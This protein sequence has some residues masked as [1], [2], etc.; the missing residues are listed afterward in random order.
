M[1]H[2][3]P[4][5][6]SI[7]EKM[8]EPLRQ[9]FRTSQP[10]LLGTS[11]ATGF[12]ETAVRSGVRE[13]VLVVDG[14]YFGD[15]F[16]KVA[17]AC[18]KEVVRVSIHPGRALEPDQLEQ[19][20]DGPDVDAVALV[21]SETS[22]GALAPLEELA[23]VIRARSSALIL[24]DAVTSLGASPVETDEWGLDFVFTGSQK[25]LAVPPGLALA[26][27]S[28]RMIA[29]A[30][31]VDA[32]GWYLDVLLHDAAARKNQPT[33]TPAMPQFFAL[34]AQLERIDAEGGIEARWRRHREMQLA[35]ERW[36]VDHPQVNFLAPEG[37]RSWAVSALEV[38]GERP[39]TEIV[40]S[41][42]ERGWTLGAGLDEMA[43]RLI[44]IGHMGDLQV[45]HVEEMLGVLGEELTGSSVRS[46]R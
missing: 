15:R 43:P 21:H 19:F 41:M 23:R 35:V 44:R 12:M 8:Q 32:R 20:L 2:R 46:E 4:V 42:R 26:V 31:A 1:S 17:E 30:H 7:L 5:M 25:A 3:S 22:T 10:V 14:G 29:R 40:K 36:Q 27:A 38:Q 45:E 28:E 18:G 9:L 16:A 24:V 13:R 39:A 11:S 37:R 33:Q 34:K 6:E